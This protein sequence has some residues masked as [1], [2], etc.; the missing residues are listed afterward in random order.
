[1][2][3]KKNKKTGIK[4]QDFKKKKWFVDLKFKDFEYS[5][6]EDVL[7]LLNDVIK[8]LNKT[9]DFNKALSYAI[10]KICVYST[11]DLGHCFI[12]SNDKLVSSKIWNNETDSKFDKLKEMAEKS[13]FNIGEGIPGI[14]FENRKPFWIILNEI[15]FENHFPKIKL[16]RKLGINTGVWIPVLCG[17]NVIAVMEFLSIL[18]KPPGKQI[19]NAIVNIADELGNLMEK[20]IV[21]EKI[22]SREKLL[23]ETQRITKVGSWEKNLITGEVYF[24]EE[25]YNILNYE[26]KDEI[27][28]INEMKKYIH[29]EDIH[30]VEKI[31]NRFI[32]N[33]FP[34]DLKFRIITKDGEEKYLYA[35]TQVD[36]DSYKKPVRIYGSIQ[37]ITNIKQFEDELYTTNKKLLETQRELIHSE[38]LAALGRF[39]AGIAHEIRN[40]LANISALS[41]L[42]LKQTE[43]SGN[44]KHLQMI[45][46]NTNIANQIIK[47]LLN[48]ASPEEPVLSDENFGDIL[49]DIIENI[50]VRCDKSG[51]NLKVKTD[52][53]L[54]VILADKLRIKTAMMNFISNAIDAMPRG[55]DLIIKACPDKNLNNLIIEITD[56]GIGIQPDNLDKIFE[57]FF[58]TKHNGTGLGLGL[59]HQVIKSHNGDVKI[60]SKLKSGTTVEL[61]LPVKK[62][63]NEK[64][65]FNS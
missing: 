49:N 53:N 47:D 30:Q 42:L 35:V 25:L 19:I 57:P 12:L 56:N 43:I 1:M 28:L 23:K 8:Y 46:D 9:D 32:R 59:A 4:N 21:M 3:K 17:D 24:S 39:S 38:K 55:G 52:E 10:N 62:V 50:R 45:L 34:V 13:T 29:Q 63:N 26:N 2:E 18:E 41:Q 60:K 37:D 36:T 33:P 27:P 40:P 31:F 48:Y 64:Q 65:N 61:F 22:R 54:P 51:I 20:R 16:A 15:Y 14:C 6:P 5:D 44:K 11:W 7:T 58:T